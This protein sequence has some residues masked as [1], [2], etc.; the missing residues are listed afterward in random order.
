VRASRPGSVH[1]L[2]KLQP[3]RVIPRRAPALACATESPSCIIEAVARRQLAANSRGLRHRSTILNKP[4]LLAVVSQFPK[5]ERKGSMSNY[6]DFIS[7]S[8]KRCAAI[9]PHQVDRRREVTLTLMVAATTIVVPSE[10]LEVL[11]D[12]SDGPK[13]GP[14]QNVTCPRCGAP[15]AVP[16]VPSPPHPSHDSETY[17][18][19]KARLQCLL[20]KPFVGSDLWPTSSPGSWCFGEAKDVSD[21]PDS[22]PALK[23]PKPLSRK[24]V[25]KTVVKHIR[26]ALAHGNII[27]RGR[28]EVDQIVLLTLRAKDKYEFL[29]VTPADFRTFLDNW[30]T[31]LKELPLPSG[32]VAGFGE[33]AA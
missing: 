9:L 32:V 11:K 18:D 28:P 23:E 17:Q 22:W 24:K 29:S 3:F 25:A 7:D 10:R 2:H 26:N 33:A 8:P 1:S 12:G 31:C 13:S 4:V 16:R 20:K 27:T 6:N 19:A 21:D 5:C 30:L 15:V 14:D